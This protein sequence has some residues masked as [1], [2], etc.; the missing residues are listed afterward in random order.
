M[1]EITESLKYSFISY[2]G[3][4]LG[5]CSTIFLYTSELKFYGTLRY[6]LAISLLLSSFFSLGLNA[7]TVKLYNELRIKKYI[8]AF[9]CFS[10]IVI[11]LFSIFCYSLSDYLFLKLGFVNF[12]NLKNFIFPIVCLYSLNSL[13]YSFLANFYIT[14][15]P[16]IFDSLLPKINTILSFI[17]FV[18]SKDIK[19]SLFLFI[20][21][22]LL[23]S[24]V[25]FIYMK[26]MTHLKIDFNF[27]FLKDMHI[28]KEIMNF[29]FFSLFNSFLYAIISQ[30][31]MI[32]LG[33]A[34]D[35]KTNGLYG[36]ILSIIGLI[37]IPLLALSKSSIPLISNYIDNKNIKELGVFYKRTSLYLFFLGSFL[38]L[39]I[40]TNFDTLFLILNK[41]ELVG[42][43]YI[44]AILGT[45]L[46]VDLLTGINGNIINRSNHYK[47]NTIFIIITALISI[48]VGYLLVVRLNYG[49]IGAAISTSTSMLIY[50]ILKLLFNYKYFNISPF[51]KEMI[52]IIISILIILFLNKNLNL[53]N[54][55]NPFL[56]II[57]NTTIIILFYIF[58]NYYYKI[59]TF[60]NIFKTK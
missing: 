27:G 20:I 21:L 1:G 40:I 22:S 45:S 50:N 48:I 4:F 35:L 34:G 46:L 16:N 31:G 25:L 49:I 23:S 8:N 33:E 32:I 39:I 57:F 55:M 59:V 3:Y 10:I 30:I 58:I 51:S 38:F 28:K 44:I 11:L 41:K 14:A 17:F 19:A 54:L 29:S 7:T 47:I 12:W 15:I 53:D 24:F 5:I 37:N 9:I 43:F 18:Y 52:P 42:N 56:F 6:I 2:C 36:I 60:K 26:K 13:F